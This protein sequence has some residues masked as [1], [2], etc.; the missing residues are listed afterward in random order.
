MQKLKNETSLKEDNIMKANETKNT[1]VATKETTKKVAEKKTET[2][3]PA[4][5][6]VEN[7]EK[8]NQKVTVTMQEV[9]DM[10]TKAGIKIYNPD[11][12][13]NYRIMGSKKGSSINLQTKKYIIFSTDDDY[14]AVEAVKGKYQDLVLGKGA[15]SQDKSRPNSVEFTALE[16]LKGLLAVYA[17]NPANKPVAAK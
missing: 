2:K 10:M 14:A 17:K 5:K 16:T 1:K 8:K 6:K 12:K 13:G 3:K 7:K 15:N 9:V 11:G 4:T